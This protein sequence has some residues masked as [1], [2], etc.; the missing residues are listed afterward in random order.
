MNPVSGLP[1]VTL[2]SVEQEKK[3]GEEEAKKVEVPSLHLGMARPSVT[4][5]IDRAPLLILVHQSLLV[6]SLRQGQSCWSEC[7][8]LQPRCASKWE[9]KWEMETILWLHILRNLA[10]P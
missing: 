9:S 7:G 1:E 5:R 4:A 10:Q 2:I 3:I 8:R 6:F